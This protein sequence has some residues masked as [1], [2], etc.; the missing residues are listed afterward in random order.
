MAKVTPT[1]VEVTT[2]VPG[3][4]LELSDAEA[5]TLTLVLAMVGGDGDR[6]A[7]KHTQSVYDALEA[8]GIDYESNLDYR[9]IE[10]SIR[11]STT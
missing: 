2:K 4:T 3:Y 10:G 1:E 8:A 7:R 6:S 11:F 9:R 5:Q